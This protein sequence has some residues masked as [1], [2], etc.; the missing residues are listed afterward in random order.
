[1]TESITSKELFE[2]EKASYINDIETEMATMRA[3]F[4]ALVLEVETYKTFK[5]AEKSVVLQVTKEN[6]D[7][8]TLLFELVTQKVVKDELW[9]KKIKSVLRIT[10]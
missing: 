9:L 5:D 1:M 8:Y 3:A 6:N 10:N 7:Y 4:D 2:K